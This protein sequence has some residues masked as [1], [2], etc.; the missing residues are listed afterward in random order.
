M[1]HAE[2]EAILDQNIEG[3][4]ELIYIARGTFFD[5]AG[6]L[7]NEPGRFVPAAEEPEG[8]SARHGPGLHAAIALH[9]FRC[10]GAGGRSVRSRGSREEAVAAIVA[11]YPEARAEILRIIAA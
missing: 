9:C 3:A 8:W 4:N 7:L 6:S 1:R 10:A 11:Q 5:E 2:D